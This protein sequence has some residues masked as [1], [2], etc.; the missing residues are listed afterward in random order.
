M[1]SFTL[2][3]QGVEAPISIRRARIHQKISH[4]FLLE[5]EG[6]F[7]N[8]MLRTR[9]VLNKPAVFSMAA[10]YSKVLHGGRAGFCGMVS[11]FSIL[12]AETQGLSTCRLQIVPDC[13]LLSQAIHSRIRLNRTVPEIVHL[14]FEEAGFPFEMHAGRIMHPRHDMKTQYHESDLHFVNR[15]CEEEGISYFFQ[16]DENRGSPIIFT[17]A[18]CS[19]A[20]RDGP[21]LLYVDNPNESAEKEFVTELEILA[22]T[23][24]GS[25][26]IRDFDPRVPE[27]KFFYEAKVDDG[28]ER[29]VEHSIFGPGFSEVTARGPITYPLADKGGPVI[30]DPRYGSERAQRMLSALRSEAALI[31]FRTNALDLAPGMVINIT[32]YPLPDIGEQ[33]RLLIIQSEFEGEENQEWV[34]RVWAVFGEQPYQ[35]ML[36][37]PKPL[38]SGVY[39]AIVVGPQGEEIHTDELGRVR[40][41]FPWDREGK[42]DEHS[43]CWIRVAQPWAGP[44]LGIHS[45]PRIG[46]E[47]LISFENSDPDR[48]IVIGR[49]ANAMHPP[50]YPLPDHKAKTVWRSQ[51][52]PGGQGYNEL[53]FDDARGH[54]K[55]FVHAQRDRE[56]VI[57][58]DDGVN[59]GG[60]RASL[61]GA[62]EERIVKGSDFDFI[63]GD[64]HSIIHGEQRCQIGGDLSLIGGG[65]GNISFQGR[66]AIEAKGEIHLISGSRI[67]IEAGQVSIKSGGGFVDVNGGGVVIDGAVVLIKQGGS[68]ASGGGSHPKEPESPV[69]PASFVAS[70]MPKRIVRL[71]LLGMPMGQFNHGGDPEKAIICQAICNCQSE[72]QTQTEAGEQRT[73][74]WCVSRKLWAY[75]D[76]LGNQST[77]NAECPYDMSQSP[78]APIMS[79]NVPKRPTR[80]RP[81]GSKIPDII[82]KKDP[83]KP[84]TQDNIK[85][86]IEVKF[87]SDDIDDEHR[88]D[89]K[90]IAGSA[91]M[92]VWRPEDCNCGQ[93]EPD[94][95]PEPIT[96]ADAV[97]IMALLVAIAALLADDALP[98]GQADDVA[99]PPLI[100]RLMA[101]LAPIL[102]KLRLS[103]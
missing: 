69:I 86:V 2:R 49:V 68:P 32:G 15:L 58:R 61:I 21:P 17:D 96:V 98:G 46:Q 42:N 91:P 93:E 75:D 82:I 8:T 29:H 18:P 26:F 55:I 101:R 47:V 40:V 63:D 60:T 83:T 33:D 10:G 72:G 89:Y 43:S 67:V 48:P 11:E 51:T 4:P 23:C 25:I 85:K 56:A 34:M 87:G 74:Q 22:K 80:R 66:L 30:C 79:K 13:W 44:A 16:F 88:D 1:S 6:Y 77:I 5:L 54:E 39:N 64:V 84:P 50:P 76:A 35:P 19:A 92:E 38:M 36:R 7:A 59:V 102:S 73:M 65:D 70:D 41:Q 90:R 71:P 37:T 81:L 14:L 24:P 31:S 78:P 9:D 12:K 20:V 95:V 100:A 62:D 52:S 28:I 27:R 99:I 97:L 3:V 94:L 57:R 45:V 53:S 103:F